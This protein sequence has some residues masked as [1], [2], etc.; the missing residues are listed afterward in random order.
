M[1]QMMIDD[2]WLY[3]IEKASFKTYKLS[4]FG[5]QTETSTY[6]CHVDFLNNMVILFKTA[7]G[8]AAMPEPIGISKSA[9]W[10]AGDYYVLSCGDARKQGIAT[11]R[12]IRI[13]HR[14][15][16]DAKAI[17]IPYDLRLN[18]R[19]LDRSAKGR[20]AE[21]VVDIMIKRGLIVIPAIFVPVSSKS[22][23]LEGVDSES[24]NIP[25]QVK[26]DKGCYRRGVFL[27]THEWNHKKEF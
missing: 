10:E 27:Q 12:G 16:N 1:S 17:E 15:I 3:P 11:A 2:S 7:E 22:R 4:E 5:I 8:L 20:R 6:R 24:K 21:E 25:L 9:D 14:D 19:E 23:Q 13:D 18:T 26:H